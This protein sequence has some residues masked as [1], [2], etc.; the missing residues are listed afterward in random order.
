MEF[1]KVEEGIVP[2]YEND[3]NE[4]LINAR[5]LHQALKNKRQF[6]DWIKQ[7]INRYKFLEKQDFFT[8]HKFVNRENTNL[9][10]MSIEYYVTVDMAK[11][12]CMVENNEMGRK[13]RRYFIEAEKR[14]REIINNPSNIFDF[15]RLA[16]NQIE[17][18]S[19]NIQDLQL[20]VQDIKSKID[21]S[22]KNNYCLASDIA[23]QLN[24]YSENNLPHSNF[25][26]AIARNLGYK[27]SYKHYYE[28]DYIA[29]VKDISKNEYWQ[30]YFKPLAVQEISNWFYKNKDEIYY[31]IQY[32]KNTKNGK[33]GE[34]KEKG[35][36][37]ENVCYKIMNE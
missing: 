21:V 31:E 30:V 6:S 19:K 2:I 36:K 15:M 3:T 27:I 34:I 10:N 23:E 12:L 24:L 1:K 9:G 32:V 13:I 18:N 37:I 26:G 7:R 35:Y 8:I 29:I 20:D 28:D 5:E 4:K 22:I 17:L 16:L 25:I 14:Y 11:E 33:K